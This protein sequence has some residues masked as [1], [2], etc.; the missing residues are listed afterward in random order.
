MECLSRPRYGALP[1][2]VSG[3][4]DDADTGPNQRKQPLFEKSDAKTLLLWADGSETSTAQI[5]K[6]FFASFCSQKEAFPS[7][8]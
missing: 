1:Q 2:H 7:A 6:S 8:S 3:A 5:N 4:R